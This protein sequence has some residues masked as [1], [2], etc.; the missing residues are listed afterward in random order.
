MAAEQQQEEA[1]WT[2]LAQSVS[3]L[4]SELEQLLRSGVYKQLHVELIIQRMKLFLPV[5]PAMPDTECTICLMTEDDEQSRW[6]ELPC[7]HS[8]HESC[9]LEW[10]RHATRRACPLCRL[11]LDRIQNMM[12]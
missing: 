7:G 9:L 8:Y 2:D 1:D 4:G 5:V 12:P 11:D 3:E 6:R 10:V